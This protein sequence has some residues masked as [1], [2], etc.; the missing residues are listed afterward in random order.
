MALSVH[1]LVAIVG[2]WSIILLGVS[3]WLSHLLSDRL[4]S[5]WKSEEDARLETLRS[6]LTNDRLLL[7][8]AIK[9]FES[10]Q[11]LYQEKR[12]EAVE[13]LWNATLKLRERFS[14]AVFFFTILAPD[15]YDDALKT[16]QA[17][18]ASIEPIN[19]AMITGAMKDDENLERVRPYLGET[20]W[21][22]YFIYRAFMGRLSYLI[23]R[24]K[25]VGRFSGDWR[26]DKLIRQL[27]PNV[28]P[29][30]DVVGILKRPDGFL[31]VQG[32]R[33][34]LESV[35]LKEMSLITSGKRSSAESF[36]NA[37]QMRKIIASLGPLADRV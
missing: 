31:L 25:K 35:M 30:E 6:A 13:V 37:T 36:E 19:D 10:G 2:G 8:S 24:A 29:P 18:N 32:V 9:S 11:T 14:A 20:L 3:S 5:K 27:L 22:Q 1:S 12:L 7:E 16:D 4:I 23:V 17:L 26:D 21:S 34:S 33:G 28:L 15:E